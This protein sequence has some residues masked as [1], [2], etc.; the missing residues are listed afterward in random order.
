MASKGMTEK[1]F[2][3]RGN[4]IY[5]K[6]GRPEPAPAGRAERPEA[7]RRGPAPGPRGEMT[8][9]AYLR[10]LI[11]RRADPGRL[12]RGVAY[13]SEGRVVDVTVESGRI[14][15]KVAGS[16]PSPFAVAVALP[17]RSADEL[18][19]VARAL[20]TRPSAVERARRG[21]YT[22]GV[23]DIFLGEDLRVICDCPDTAEPC[24]HGVAVIHRLAAA[25][26]KDSSFVLRAR[27]LDFTWLTSMLSRMAKR[28]SRDAATAT[29][30]RF[31]RGSG[32][33]PL[34]DPA[35]APA[36]EESDLDLLHRA[37]RS[38]S[39][40]AVEQL[41]AVSDIEEMFDYLTRR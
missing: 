36:I 2:Q 41:R 7:S 19:D 13:F 26:D 28:G 9:G 14:E 12:D 3:R 25:M 24:K 29:D 10:S 33:P 15:A 21:R 17:Y 37:M 27:G 18:S 39:F 40:T 20:A 23:L 6:F 4:V 16:Q 31:W 38:V 5:A 22:V 30:E 8:P 34:P 1:K 32:L 11:A 35:V